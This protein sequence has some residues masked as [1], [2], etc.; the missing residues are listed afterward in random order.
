M[1][2]SFYHHS[3]I[4]SWISLCLCN[5]ISIKL[6][7]RWSLEENHYLNFWRLRIIKGTKY[8]EPHGVI[9][10]FKELVSPFLNSYLFIL[11]I[12]IIITK[13]NYY[14]E[15]AA[16]FNLLLLLCTFFYQFDSFAVWHKMY[17]LFFHNFLSSKGCE[18][19]YRSNKY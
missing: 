16:S 18:Y 3:L 8:T 2:S 9:R 11:V 10:D 12:Q 15:Q 4:F 7:R 5:I 13:S 14:R 19:Y 1:F 6:I 17:H